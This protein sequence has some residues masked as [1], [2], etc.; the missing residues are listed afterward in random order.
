ML[1]TDLRKTTRRKG[2]E[3]LGYRYK[4]GR[5]PHGEGAWGHAGDIT[6][7]FRVALRGLRSDPRGLR[8][9]EFRKIEKA[10][11]CD[12]DQEV[13]D[14]KGNWGS[15]WPLSQFRTEGTTISTAIWFSETTWKVN[16]KWPLGWTMFGPLVN[17]GR[18]HS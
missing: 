4:H 14:M 7:G 6:L 18:H 3:M 5:W 11:T 12:R 2:S 8:L 13:R 17:C 10:S 16:G 9:S 15:P 1:F